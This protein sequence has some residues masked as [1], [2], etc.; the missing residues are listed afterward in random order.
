MNLVK[1]TGSVCLIGE[2]TTKNWYNSNVNAGLL[3]ADQAQENLV[4]RLQDLADE[5]TKRDPNQEGLFSYIQNKLNP[6]KIKGVYVY[7]TVGRGKSFLIDG[8]FLNVARKDKLRVHFH[9]FMRHFHQDMKNLEDKEDALVEVANKLADKYSLICFDE[10]HVSDITDAMILARMLEVLIKRGVVIVASSNYAP[11]DLYKNGLARDRFLPAIKL[12]KAN[13]DVLNLDGDFDYRLRTLEKA[14]LYY[15]PINAENITNFTAMFENLAKNI[16]LKN[17]IRVGSRRMPV[18]RRTS[19]AL[20]VEFAEICGGNYAQN[21]Y[22]HI[23]ERFTTIFLAN[24]PQLGTSET[25][26]STRRFTWLIDILYEAKIKLIILAENSLANL[27]SGEGGESG[28]T[29]SRLEEMQSLNYLKDE[30]KAI[31]TKLT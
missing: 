9:G 13:L 22:L 24:V 4:I 19:D 30:I 2:D 29:L 10:F 17:S 7:G 8:F 23:A 11:D 20:W 14:N 21:D 1:P 31:A 26:E 18:V 16:S 12:I 5:L 6:P 15:Q 3:Q 25:T 27:F 28:R